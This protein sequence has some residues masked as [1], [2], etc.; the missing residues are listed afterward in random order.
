VPKIPT[1]GPAEAKDDKDE[2]PQ[3]E[4]AIKMLEI[5]SPP[6]EAK[7]PKVQKASA[8]T[9]KWRRMANVRDD[10]LETTKAL[11]PAPTK[12]IA[13]A[14]KAQ[15]K[16]ETGQA[17]AEATKAQAEVEA[18]PSAPVATKPVALEEKTTGQIAPEKIETPALEALIENVDYIIQHAWGRNCPK[19]K[20]LKPDI[21]R[22]S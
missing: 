15:A 8:A 13:E 2:E 17:E 12:K 4:K 10:V 7:L 14:A 6:T 20:F 9:H 18:G 5:M 1:V 11:S 19:K 3:V 22:E 21:M 16:A